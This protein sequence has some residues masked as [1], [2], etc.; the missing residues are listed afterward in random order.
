[1]SELSVPVALVVGNVRVPGNIPPGLEGDRG[2]AAARQALRVIEVRVLAGASV[3]RPSGRRLP[4]E[5][6]VDELAK[7]TDRDLVPIEA[8]LAHRRRV[9][10]VEK[11]DI[12]V[13][14][15]ERA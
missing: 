4:C 3:R 6:R 15:E 12:V 2:V 14:A 10:H 7:S 9:A 11:L 8:E 5:R 13:V 1:M